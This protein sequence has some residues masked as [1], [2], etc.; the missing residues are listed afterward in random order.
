MKKV[1]FVF[2]SPRVANYA[3]QMTDKGAAALM[4]EVRPTSV[5]TAIWRRFRYSDTLRFR[6]SDGATHF[7]RINS[8]VG[9]SFKDVIQGEK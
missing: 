3:T 8:V 5:L 9:I 1:I 7:I 4:K 6:S 2:S